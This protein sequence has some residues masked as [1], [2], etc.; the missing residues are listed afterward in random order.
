[1][2]C[3]SVALTRSFQHT[4]VTES[5]S[6]DRSHSLVTCRRNHR[7]EA[8]KSQWN[9]AEPSRSH[10][11]PVA[12]RSPRRAAHLAGAGTP[13]VDAGPQAHAEQVPRRPV[14]Q[15]EV[16]V[17]LQL[18]S[19]QHF[20]GDLGDLAG[21]FPRRAEQL[22]AVGSVLKV[23]SLHLISAAPSESRTSGYLLLLSGERE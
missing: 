14:Y 22:V 11:K 5:P 4:D 15:V 10:W 8:S 17:V 21:R 3:K 18:R 9:P 20:E 1:M 6:T 23:S 16:E 2:Q 7:G 19:V 12:A 13:Q